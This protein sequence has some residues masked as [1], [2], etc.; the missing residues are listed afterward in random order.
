MSD[1]EM[2]HASRELGD[3]P[4]QGE[5]EEGSGVDLR[6]G[7]SPGDSSDEEEEEGSEAERAVRQGELL[8]CI[9]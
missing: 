2:E 7:M 4:V 1:V 8:F 6:P 9:C 5:D 3:G